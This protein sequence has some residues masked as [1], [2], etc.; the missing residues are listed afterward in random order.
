[1][2]TS[3]TPAEQ[4]TDARAP[5]QEKGATCEREDRQEEQLQVTV[6]RVDD[7]PLPPT[8]AAAE[9]KTGGRQRRKA[10]EK[11]LREQAST[12]G[13]ESTAGWEQAQASEM[14]VPPTEPEDEY[15]AWM[16][17]LHT[18]RMAFTSTL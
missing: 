12:K 10:R 14:P 17:M 7:A 1:M 15:A 11:Q 9:S 13:T 6:D 18:R 4:A 5:G 16:S 8:P 2:C 3:T